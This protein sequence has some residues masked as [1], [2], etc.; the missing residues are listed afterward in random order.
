MISC[1]LQQFHIW[2]L[3]ELLSEYHLLLAVCHYSACSKSSS[4]DKPVGDDSSVSPSIK[5]DSVMEISAPGLMRPCFPWILLL[6]SAKVIL[7]CYDWQLA[8]PCIS[9]LA[10]SSDQ[11]V[12]WYGCCWEGAATPLSVSHNTLFFKNKYINFG[13]LLI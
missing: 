1:T 3:L 12:E 11:S 5:N 6:H 13:L 4:I 9:T 2:V 8:S 7:L 10:R